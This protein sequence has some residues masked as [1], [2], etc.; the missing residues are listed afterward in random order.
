[1]SIHE[2]GRGRGREG[3]SPVDSLLRGEPGVGV[4]GR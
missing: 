3:E 2:W 1:M 4:A